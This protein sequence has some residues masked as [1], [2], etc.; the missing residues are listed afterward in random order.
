MKVS[1]EYRTKVALFRYQ[2]IAPVISGTLKDGET[3]FG[4]FKRISNQ[5]HI[6]QDD[7][8]I[9]ISPTTLSRYH[10]AFLKG[11]FEGL[12]PQA[13]TDIG[14]AR[15]LSQEAKDQIEYLHTAYPRLPCTLILSKLIETGTVH[16]G[17]VSLSTVTRYV[18][19]MA[20]ET[21]ENNK[22]EYKRYEL[23]HINDVWYGDSA[24][25]PYLKVNGE[26]KRL[27]VIALI[28]DASRMIVG[29]DI[30]FN[31]NYVN[32][33]SVIRSAV[34]KFGKP[35]ALK[36]DNGSNYRS[37]QMELMTA[38]LGSSLRYA[39]PRTPTG[40]A[41]IERWFR[42]MK[43]QW[44][45]SL[46]M[47]DF[48]SIDEVRTSL[49]NYVQQYNRRPHSSLE[50]QAPQDRFFQEGNYIIRIDDNKVD[51]IF[52]MEVERKVSK[53]GVVTIE[54]ELYEVDS[55]YA[56]KTITLRYSQDLKK[57]YVYDARSGTMEEIRLLNKIQNSTLPRK[58][59]SFT[60]EE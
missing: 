2:L 16:K 56:G 22:V 35:K 59:Y 33:L 46:N 19:R 47:N 37:K 53:D 57:V 14:R 9:R 4:Y 43:D 23:E 1:E 13:R 11:G 7:E 27:Y 45:A 12:K 38:R 24:V 3:V 54:N 42:T 15:K 40:K 52:A 31:D 30:F 41:K 26:K 20:S 58:Q 17:E 25:G 36:F 21:N 51:E 44:M 29:I 32:L 39:P 34:L 49:F 48:K 5:M 28:D 60:E 8:L 55:R 6:N 18:K 10:K 50:N